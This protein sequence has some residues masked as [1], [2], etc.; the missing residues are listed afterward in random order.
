M[1]FLGE[2]QKKMKILIP[3]C[4]CVFFTFFAELSWGLRDVRVTVPLA[5]RRGDNAQLICTYDL[6]NDTLYSVKWYKGRRE[7]YRYLPKENPAMKLFTV[8][9]ITVDVS[10][11]C[12]SHCFYIC[13]TFIHSFI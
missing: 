8:T 13:H 1:N 11:K 12:T 4:R 7:F 10:T 9:G 2:E 5:V 6:E 3:S